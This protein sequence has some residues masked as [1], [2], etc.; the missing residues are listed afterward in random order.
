VQD[1]I[2]FEVADSARFAGDGYDLVA[3]FD[4]FHDLGD[5]LGTATHVCKSLAADGT[6]LIVEPAAAD[7]V[8]D[9]INPVSR[10]FYAASTCICVPSSLASEGPALGAQAGQS[11]LEGMVR[12]AGFKRFRRA[13]QTPFNLVLE[14]RP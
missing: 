12:Q 6:F 8:E 7:R 2:R 14:A 3:L 10:L 1:R 4:C 9:N 5:P 13:T 11:R